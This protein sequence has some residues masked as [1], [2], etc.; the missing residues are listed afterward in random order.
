MGI[1]AAGSGSDSPAGHDGV[2]QAMGRIDKLQP[3]VI[4]VR[5]HRKRPRGRRKAGGRDLRFGLG[6]AEI[7]LDKADHSSGDVVDVRGHVGLWAE[8]YIS[9][10]QTDVITLDSGALMEYLWVEDAAIERRRLERIG[11]SYRQMIQA[12]ALQ[13]QQ[14]FVE[15]SVEPSRG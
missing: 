2:E 6:I 8:R 13:R 5:Q 7:G 9:G 12:G 4:R 11:N 3:E 1:S 14:L 10:A 15:P